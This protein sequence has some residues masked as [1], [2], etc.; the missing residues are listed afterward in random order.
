MPVLVKNF[1]KERNVMDKS[2][3][4]FWRNF[5]AITFVFMLVICCLI[6]FS[7]IA[8][9]GAWM[10]L[11]EILHLQE[12]IIADGLALLLAAIVFLLCPMLAFHL[13]LNRKLHL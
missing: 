9:K 6:F 11:I 8:F 12:I 1:K 3:L 4:V 13:M 5:T 10:P 7:M 2:K